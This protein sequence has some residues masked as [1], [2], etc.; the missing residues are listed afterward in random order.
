MIVTPDEQTIPEG[1]LAHPARCSTLDHTR[2]RTAAAPPASSG[3]ARAYPLERRLSCL[4]G[5]GMGTL[6]GAGE[7]HLRDLHRPDSIQPKAFLWL[8]RRQQAEH[9]F[10]GSTE[11]R[12]HRLPDLA[13]C[14]LCGQLLILAPE[15][16]V[17]LHRR[18]QGLETISRI[19]RHAKDEASCCRDLHRAG[20]TGSLQKSFAL[21]WVKVYR[22]SP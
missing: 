8:L 21:Q 12:L 7:D 15:A 5:S 17:L 16:S 9:L 10:T 2:G 20:N 19:H 13:H 6:H 1:F 18:Y 4:P 14:R 3:P 22:H 11:I